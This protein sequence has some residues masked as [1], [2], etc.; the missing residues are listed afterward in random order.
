[1]SCTCDAILIVVKKSVFFYLSFIFIIDVCSCWLFVSRMVLLTIRLFVAMR[2]IALLC[3]PVKGLIKNQYHYFVFCCCNYRQHRQI[4]AI[5]MREVEEECK[6]AFVCDAV[7]ARKLNFMGNCRDIC[8]RELINSFSPL[9][10]CPALTSLFIF[11][12]VCA[13]QQ[14]RASR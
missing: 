3:I 1:M 9:F 13:A 6:C 4:Y 5:T 12:Y 8:A 10:L 14:T 11:S 7:T 2:T